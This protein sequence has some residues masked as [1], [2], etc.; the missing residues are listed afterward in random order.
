MFLRAASRNIVWSGSIA[1]PL[2]MRLFIPRTTPVLSQ[3]IITFLFSHWSDHDVNTYKIAYIS[4]QLMCFFQ[5]RLG[6]LVE[7]ISPVWN[8]TPPIPFLPLASVAIYTFSRFDCMT[9]VPDHIGRNFFHHARLCRAAFDSFLALLSGPQ[10]MFHMCLRKGCPMGKTATQNSSSP[11]NSW[12]FFIGTN[13]YFRILLMSAIAW[14]IFS[15]GTLASIFS[16][17]S[18]KPR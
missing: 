14:F 11:S 1:L 7:K 9:D 18:I 8:S 2:I 4:F 10:N 3:N 15:S 12:S 13:V 6:T 17:S 16:V 5:W